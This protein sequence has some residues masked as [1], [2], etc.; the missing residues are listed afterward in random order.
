VEMA[1]CDMRNLLSSI[2]SLSQS[3]GRRIGRKHQ[4]TIFDAIAAAMLSR[5]W[6]IPAETSSQPRGKWKRGC[7][8]AGCCRQPNALLDVTIVARWTYAMHCTTSWDV[9]P[10]TGGGIQTQRVGGQPRAGIFR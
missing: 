5:A 8:G 9:L 1:G 3:V 6:L 10:R 2:R 4:Q 7:A